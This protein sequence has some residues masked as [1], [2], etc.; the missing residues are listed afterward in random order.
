M[1]VPILDFSLVNLSLPWDYAFR[2]VIEEISNINDKAVM[3]IMVTDTRRVKTGKLWQIL[4]NDEHFDSKAAAGPDN[5]HLDVLR[6]VV[7]GAAAAD[8][9]FGPRVDPGPHR[10]A[11][12]ESLSAAVS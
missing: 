3:L 5:V 4:R 12:C 2:F 10:P 9:Q 8:Q 1:Y 7:A 11:Q 6:S